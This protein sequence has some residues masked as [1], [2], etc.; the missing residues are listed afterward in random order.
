MGQ[1]GIVNRFGTRRDEFN[2]FTGSSGGVNL[3]DKLT[4]DLDLN[5]FV[6]RVDE[7]MQDEI[8]CNFNSIFDYE[9]TPESHFFFVVVDNLPGDR[10]VFA[11]LA[12]IFESSRPDF[13]QFN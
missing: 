10:A 12:Y 5:N 4:N 7:R 3:F 6:E 1:L 8:R 2:R 9:F 13:A 11:K